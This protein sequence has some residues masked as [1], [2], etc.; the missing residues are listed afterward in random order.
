[1]ASETE[2]DDQG[3]VLYSD[4]Y[5][6]SDRGGGDTRSGGRRSSGGGS[7]LWGGRFS[8]GSGG[9]G[10][11][12]LRG[13]PL[14]PASTSSGGRSVSSDALTDPLDDFLARYTCD[15]VPDVVVGKLKKR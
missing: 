10:G 3:S 5:T 6:D 14:P 15:I 4:P 7:G 13:V 8:G 11:G 12:G 1:M 9:G 2:D